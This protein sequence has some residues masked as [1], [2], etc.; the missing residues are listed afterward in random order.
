MHGSR[1]FDTT[2]QFVLLT[3][4]SLGHLI[5]Y[6]FVSEIL[7]QRNKEGVSV[8]TGSWTFA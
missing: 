1:I 2:S 8:T 3:C 6:C 5:S 7:K 4:V